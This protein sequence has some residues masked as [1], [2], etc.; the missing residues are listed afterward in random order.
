MVDLPSAAVLAEHIHAD[1][2]HRI[3]RSAALGS[4]LPQHDTS[5]REVPSRGLDLHDGVCN[6]KFLP[7]SQ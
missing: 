3:W 7:R 2:S 5:V 6:V 4:L 1:I